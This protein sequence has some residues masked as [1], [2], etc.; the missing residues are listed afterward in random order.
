LIGEILI[1]ASGV[2]LG[3]VF[4]DLIKESGIGNDISYSY[5][6]IVAVGLLP[7]IAYFT[8]PVW[9]HGDL[10]IAGIA[11]FTESIFLWLT[12]TLAIGAAVRI[13]QHYFSNR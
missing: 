6:S 5:L 4:P 9:I 13:T 3:Y 11:G 12:I 2:F 8:R 1:I 10:S 7:V